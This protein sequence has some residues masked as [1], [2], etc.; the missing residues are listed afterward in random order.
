MN[1]ERN[2]SGLSQSNTQ[3]FP[4]ETG[5]ALENAISLH[6]HVMYFTFYR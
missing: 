6:N 3:T 4:N 5:E 2:V 1:M